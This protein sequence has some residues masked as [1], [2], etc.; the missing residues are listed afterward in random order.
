MKF[1]YTLV[2]K[3]FTLFEL[4]VV[5]ILVFIVYYFVFSSNLLSKK[6][7][8]DKVSL[9]NLKSYLLT[10]DFE[11]QISTKCIED[12][13]YICYI[14]IDGEILE[15]KQLRGLFNSKPIVY[16][17]TNEEKQL[18]FSYLKLDTFEEFDIIFE[19][20]IDSNMK[21]DNLIVETENKVYILNPIHEKPFVF[22][23]LYEF[24]QY[25]ED[26][27]SEVKDAF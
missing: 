20:S 13:D 1:T 11:N 19:Y 15:N 3:S 27:I 25:Q 18:E 9:G 2:K 22:D 24:K 23:D 16:S 5:V 7:D 8:V 14:S 6:G 17:Y 12:K 10:F 26:K 4:L 21:G